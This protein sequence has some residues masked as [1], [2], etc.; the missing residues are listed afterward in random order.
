MTFD[1]AKAFHCLAYHWTDFVFYKTTSLNHFVFRVENE[2]A[3]MFGIANVN[4]VVP[5]EH[6]VQRELRQLQLMLF[7]VGFVT[8]IVLHPL[9][10]SSPVPFFAPARG[11]NFDPTREG[12]LTTGL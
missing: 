5:K 6:G 2:I 4:V 11:I 12:L 9:R 10:Y 8:R 7:S 1:Q 3:I